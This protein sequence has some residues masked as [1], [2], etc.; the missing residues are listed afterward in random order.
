[1]CQL[2][3]SSAASQL[4]WSAAA[5]GQ[6]LPEG[7][8]QSAAVGLEGFAR[9]KTHRRVVVDERRR[10]AEVRRHHDVDSGWHIDCG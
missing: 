6:G 10:K 9:W 3:A 2:D 4:R 1:M 8:P 7:S 5:R